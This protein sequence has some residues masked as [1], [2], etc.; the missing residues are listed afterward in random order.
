MGVVLAFKITPTPDIDIDKVWR[1]VDFDPVLC[2][3]ESEDRPPVS[4]PDVLAELIT[5]MPRK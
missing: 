3:S 5:I 2:N 4:G 1:L